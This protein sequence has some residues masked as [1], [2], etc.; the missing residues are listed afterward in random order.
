MKGVCTTA[1]AATAATNILAAF[2]PINLNFDFTW[3]DGSLSGFRCFLWYRQG[4]RQRVP[5]L[6][7]LTNSIV[8]FGR[9]A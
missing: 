6:K 3:S 4:R 2:L 5:A 9:V 1:A 8:L 7:Y